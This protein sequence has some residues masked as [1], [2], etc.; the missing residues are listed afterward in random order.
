M[1][2]PPPATDPEG[3]GSADPLPVELRRLLNAERE[4][5]FSDT[6]ASGGLSA[7]IAAR[8]P[9]ASQAEAPL[10]RRLSQYS[11]LRV[12]T[13]ERLLL[14]VLA[15]LD[16]PESGRARAAQSSAGPADARPEDDAATSEEGLATA[17][18]G[19]W[20]VGEK[21][22]GR[23]RGLGIESVGDLLLHRPRRYLDHGDVVP[24][25]EAIEGREVT[26]VGDVLEISARPARS[27]RL[28][29]VEAVIGD[30]TGML[31]AVWFNQP[32]LVQTLRGRSGVAF[33]GRVEMGPW[34]RGLSNPEYDVDA[35]RMV[36]AGRL[37]PVYPLTA[38][39]T[40]R[41]MRRWVTDA[42]E[43]YGHLPRDPLPPEVLRRAR[44]P[45]LGDA[46]QMVHFPDAAESAR[47]GARRLAFAELLVYQLAILR[48]RHQWREAVPGRPVAVDRDALADF[49]RRL[50]F[51]LTN[52]Q[53]E[54]LAAILNDM[55]RDQPMSRLLQGDVGA[56]KTVVAAGALF[57]AARAGWQGAMM[58]PTEV[59]AEQHA[60]TLSE[61]LGALGLRVERIT[62][63]V[64]AAA[65]RA[66]WRAVESGEVNVVVGTQALIQ[67]SARFQRL[68]LAVVDEQHRFGV[69][70]RGEIRA[71]GYN[72]HLLAMTATPIPRSLALT[73]YGD[74]DVS[75]IRSMPQGRRAI[76]THWVPSS[77]RDD[78]Y[79]FVRDEVRA[80][81]QVFIICPLIAESE[82]LQARSA[83][84]E[85]ERLQRTVYADLRER[86]GLLHGRLSGKKKEAVM[87]RFRDG[88]L[89][90]LVSTA[91]VE[92]GID[93]ANATV[94]MIEGA[95]RFGLAQLHQLRGR[96]GRGPHQSHCLLLSDTSDPSEN[97]R[98]RTLQ[99]VHDG[100]DLAE[101][102]LE[103]RGPGDIL[104][105][106][107][108][109]LLGFR[110]ATVTDFDTVM[111]ARAEAEAISAADPELTRPEHA[112]L[113]AEVGEALARAEWS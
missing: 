99:S 50:P 43:T 3:A 91:V 100:F 51:T 21:A 35:A 10:L 52:D 106:R 44:L 5:G 2:K 81:R 111:L 19:L 79:R 47:E 107:Q 9:A 74:L 41:Q 78:A 62:G 61:L 12:P 37:V 65:K 86:I 38:G 53:R 70:Q 34:G 22:A 110:F 18:T 30:E 33:A 48:H 8:L 31:T 103:L 27:R 108:H 58:A 13:R 16:G 113:A 39:V 75:S 24:I 29:I 98:L 87:R 20:G 77:K 23:L 67:Q 68:N 17:V 94:M 101:R 104:G 64:P 56:G 1:S 89:D 92:V 14:A 4:C 59:L 66:V 42:L 32:F 49:G 90:I 63:S 28:Q 105:K 73:L 95:E 82:T 7:W 96:V 76:R 46:I 83:E 69:Q 57:A 88:E 25:A 54:A 6:A 84:Q 36:H 60:A 15:E 80:G 72:P 97:A 102:D 11:R 71:K 112:G 109:G 26:V 45:A 55:R 93:V 85:H 40:Q